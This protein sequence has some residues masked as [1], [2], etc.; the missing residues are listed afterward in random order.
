[1]ASYDIQK[2]VDFIL[3]RDKPA[4]LRAIK[5]FTLLVALHAGR[6]KAIVTGRGASLSQN[7]LVISVPRQV[8]RHARLL[9]GM[10]FLDH[11]ESEWRARNPGVRAT[12]ADMAI[13][14]D[15]DRIYTSIIL[16]HGG[17]KK[18]RFTPS[19]QVFE[20]QV[21]AWKRNA[22]DVARIIDFS[23]RFEQDPAKRR[24]IGGV[25]MAIDIVTTNPGKKYFRTKKKSTQLEK[26]WSQQKSAAPFHYLLYT[27]KYPFFLKTIA[28]R[29][30]AEKWL[31]RIEDREG[32]LEF[33][34]AYNAAVTRLRPRKYHYSLLSLPPNSRTLHFNF[35][36]IR[37]TD[38]HAKGVLDAISNYRK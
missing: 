16:K 4:P 28:G 14:G 5:L 29:R 19:V 15:Y 20:R 2:A 23:T 11:F 26:A 27:R 17:W 24:L 10:K 6:S 36:P 22:R 21:R 31:A 35:D 9:A 3:N 7:S 25:T 18:I 13:V 1:M 38:E 8:L 34:A 37:D 30:F 33:F 32:L 12:L